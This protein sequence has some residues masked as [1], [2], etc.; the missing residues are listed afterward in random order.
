[1]D[2]FAL[3]EQFKKVI[4]DLQAQLVDVEAGVDAA[5]K[6]AY[7]AGFADGVASVPPPVPGDK[8]YSQEELDAA[9][10][11]AKVELQKQVDELSAK[12]AELEVKLAD[13]DAVVAAKVEEAIKAFKADLKA[14]YVA[15]QEAESKDEA[16]FGALLD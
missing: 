9:V 6:A 11:A 2:L 1:M 8:I 5:K 10:A 13:V 4:A 12:V 3:F 14:K 15:A 7:D 16:D